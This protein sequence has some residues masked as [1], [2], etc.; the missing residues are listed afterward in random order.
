MDIETTAR[1]MQYILA[2]VVMISASALILNGMHG[3]YTSL[4]HRLRD[5]SRERLKLLDSDAE[6]SLYKQERLDYIDTELPIMLNHYVQVHQAIMFMYLAVMLYVVNMFMIAIA[7]QT[8]SAAI[9]LTALA[10][11]LIGTATSLLA[12]TVNIREFR[13][14]HE[15]TE[16]EVRRALSQ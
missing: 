12:L 13:N 15:L 16:H 6:D 11:F 2:P 10:F 4:N 3:R 8:Q 9:A 14:S 5:M 1:A 7:Y